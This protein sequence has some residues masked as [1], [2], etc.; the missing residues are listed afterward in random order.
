MGWQ[1]LGIDT[2]FLIVFD[3]SCEKNIIKGICHG[4]GEMKADLNGYS[5]SNSQL[6][7]KSNLNDPFGHFKQNV[8]YLHFQLYKLKCCVITLNEL[9]QLEL[10]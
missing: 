8:K 3:G 9:S 5:L 6:A 7:Y 4:N 2:H 10:A 1:R